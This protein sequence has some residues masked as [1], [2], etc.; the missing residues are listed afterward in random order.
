MESN[1]GKCHVK[2][3]R[4]TY[5]KP[6][7]NASIKSTAGYTKGKM[8]R[9]KKTLCNDIETEPRGNWR[10]VVLATRASRRVEKIM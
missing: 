9:K 10:T 7:G 8:Q 1:I 2:S 3:T 4:Q 6:T 5:G